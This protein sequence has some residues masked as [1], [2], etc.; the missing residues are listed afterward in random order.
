MGDAQGSELHAGFLI[1][2][3]KARAADFFSLVDHVRAAVQAASGVWLEPEVRIIGRR[4][5]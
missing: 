2:L 1:N 5:T 3:G 4:D